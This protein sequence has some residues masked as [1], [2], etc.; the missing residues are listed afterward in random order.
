MFLLIRTSGPHY[1]LCIENVAVAH[2]RKRLE[3]YISEDQKKL[4]V[5]KQIY[6]ERE[7]LCALMVERKTQLK[8]ANPFPISD[9]PILPK[10]KVPPRTKEEHQLRTKLKREFAEA[11]VEWRVKK[12]QYYQPYE[13]Q[14]ER[15]IIEENGLSSNFNFDEYS[16]GRPDW[17]Y[18]DTI[19]VSY[20]IEEVPEV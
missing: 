10:C 12:M 6:L 9:P 5:E 1:E 14:A 15:E 17:M 2:D 3:A 16:Y 18:G 13:E 20:S 4:V 19:R 11:T 7:R 8:E